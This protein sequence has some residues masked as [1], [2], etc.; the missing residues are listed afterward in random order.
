MDK[1]IE[2]EYGDQ[3]S[4]IISLISSD[5]LVK[6]AEYSDE[7][8]EYIKFLKKR[9]DKT[10][11]LVNALSAGEYYGANRNNDYFPEEALKKYHKTFEALG[12]VFKHHINKNPKKAFGKVVFS[13]Y[14]PNMHRVELLLELDNIRA[15]DIIE[16]LE[17][18]IEDVR[19]SMACFLPSTPVVIDNF[20]KKSI[21]DIIVG[22]KVLTH[23]G[24]TQKVTEIHNRDYNDLIYEIT[25]VGKYRQS[26]YSTKEHPWLIIEP[27][28]FYKT[29]NYYITNRNLNLTLENT[30]WKNSEDLTGEELLVMPK[31]KKSTTDVI[32]ISTEEA[33]ILG[34]YLAEGYTRKNDFG[35]EF[36][37]NKEDQFT[38]EIEEVVKKYDKKL[39]VKIRPH[40]KSDQALSVT[41]Y[42]KDLHSKCL[43]YCGKYSHKKQLHKD[44]FN[45]NDE[46]KLSFLGA[47]ISGDGYFHKEQAYISSCN[48]QLLEQIQW[49]ALSLNL[50]TTLGLNVHKSYHPSFAPHDTNEYILRFFGNNNLVL[51]KYCN[52]IQAIEK[53]AQSGKGGPYEY[54]D[55]L[56]Y[57]IESIESKQYFGSVHNIEVEEDNSYV[58]DKWAVHNCRV[59]YDICSVCNNK[60]R[61]LSEYCEHLK[62]KMGRIL[63]DGRKVYAINTMPKFFD[64]SVVT[65]PADRTAGFLAK[66]ASADNDLN[67]SLNTEDIMPSAQIA[68]NLKKESNLESRAELKKR[69]VAEVEAVSEDPKLLIIKSQK[70]CSKKTLEKMSEYPLNEVL[71]TMLGLRIMPKK[72]DF[73]KMALYS[74]GHSKLAEDLSKSDFDFDVEDSIELPGVS[75]DNFNEKIAGLLKEEVPHMS[76]TKPYV[77]AR[78]LEKVAFIDDQNNDDVL[79]SFEDVYSGHGF[80]SSDIKNAQNIWEKQLEKHPSKLKEF[81]IGHTEDPTVTPHKNPVLP[82]AILGGL[83]TGYATLFSKVAS[84]SG[85]KGLLAKFPWLAPLLVGAGTV[86]SLKLQDAYFNKTA[87]TLIPAMI[88]A[89]LPIS[90]LYAGIQEAKVR[91]GT[92][93][94]KVQNFVRKHPFLAT[95]M[96]TGA[97]KAGGS[98]LKRAEVISQMDEQSINKL[99]EDLIKES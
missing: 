58:V 93:I 51:S 46:A 86:G 31:P 48:K 96:A 53:Q 15:V 36:S 78:A 76:L 72:E 28:D 27:E 70:S 89:G 12:H 39:K 92:P 65:I 94:T 84:Q 33:K 74:I 20:S 59:P 64:L 61:K 57:K 71:S 1:I 54:N 19:V 38:D 43:K 35:V 67:T 9:A 49:L 8:K 14:N 82:L 24:D 30:K 90:Y 83:Y 23:T 42:N 77:I 79:K 50:K 29:D 73:M 34:W 81:L 85:M 37:V 68:E 47:Y 40:G 2:Y 62:T 3:N 32:N 45:W 99:Y 52:K 60:A 7:L 88:F 10:Y 63:S 17:D 21:E 16:R 41:I 56:L 55:F 18:K 80:S 26:I 25:P 66:I 44:I 75:C 97:A 13:H 11:A 98:L 22:D 87:S 69:I 5:N 6:K 4:E 95:V 91:R